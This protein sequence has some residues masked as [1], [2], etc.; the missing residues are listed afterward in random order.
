MTPAASLNGTLIEGPVGCGHVFGANRR[1]FKAGGRPL[2]GAKMVVFAVV[3]IL[4]VVFSGHCWLRKRNETGRFGFSHGLQGRCRIIKLYGNSL[5]VQRS[6]ANTASCPVPRRGG[7]Q[8][9]FTAAPPRW[10]RRASSP[11]LRLSAGGR[12][13]GGATLA[14]ARPLVGKWKEEGNVYDR[15]DF[16]LEHVL[17]GGTER[18]GSVPKV[19]GHSEDPAHTDPHPRGSRPPVAYT[20]TGAHI[21]FCFGQVA[22]LQ[23]DGRDRE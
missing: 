14:G 10:P 7:Q 9:R 3:G 1:G 8:P 5:W 20:T 17:P 16:A 23:L 21:E 15:S 11:G 22:Y 4:D 19:D 13:T 6:I 12:R 2:L 18:V